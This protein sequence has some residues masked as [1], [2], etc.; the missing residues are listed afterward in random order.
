M[1]NW[2]LFSKKVCNVQE[3][4]KT[5]Q[6]LVF[7]FV[8]GA[9]VECLKSGDWLLLDEIN[10]ASAETL[11]YLSGLLDSKSGSLLITERGFV[12]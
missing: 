10:L 9:L 7:D 8:E 11:E 5:H 2:E 3:K 6:A 12:L 4:T 1:K